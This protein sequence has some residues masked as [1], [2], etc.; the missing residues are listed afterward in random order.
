MAIKKIYLVRHGQ[1]DYNKRG[2]VQGSGIDAPLN[3][4]GKAQAHA[5][6]EAYKSVAFDKIYVSSL[7]RTRQ[8]VQGFI[9]SGIPYEPLADLNEISWGDYEGVPMTPDENVYYQK[10]L[11]TW[12]SGQLDYAIRGGESPLQVQ[13]RLQ[14]ALDYILSQKEETILICMHGR[15]I[16]ILLATLLKY[17]LSTMD[18]FTHANLCLYELTYL[19]QSFR[20][21]RFDERGHLN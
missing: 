4:T 10:M 13:A 5:F 21:D 20:I 16:R 6:F 14:V 7:Q 9:D 3:E 19:G 15:A 12:Q 1:T 18:V 8:S 17:H 2:I 11:T